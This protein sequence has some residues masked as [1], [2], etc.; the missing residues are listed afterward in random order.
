MGNDRVDALAKEAAVEEVAQYSPG[1]EFGDV[2][3]LLDASGCGDI[4]N[5]ELVGSSPS[6]GKRNG[7]SGWR[8]STQMEWNSTGRRRCAFFVPQK[9]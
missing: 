6:G 7:G 8:S 9:W 5:P 3:Q 1:P 2:V 4:C